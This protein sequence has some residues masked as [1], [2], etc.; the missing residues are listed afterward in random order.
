MGAA[1][2]ICVHRNVFCTVMANC[3]SGSVYQGSGKRFPAA[4]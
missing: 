2:N 1:V 3:C 4:L